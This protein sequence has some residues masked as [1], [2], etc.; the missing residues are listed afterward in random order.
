MCTKIRIPP[1]IAWRDSTEKV[2]HDTMAQDCF[3]L[4]QKPFQRQ[5]CPAPASAATS[6]ATASLARFPI[7]KPMK[8][9]KYL[10]T[11]I[12]IQVCFW[13]NSLL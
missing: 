4:Q 5:I 3:I 13:V 1:A 11:A 9:W 2:L 6:P 12:A 10:Q 8:N 7:K